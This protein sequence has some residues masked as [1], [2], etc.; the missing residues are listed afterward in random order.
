MCSCRLSG[1]TYSA[2]LL[3]LVSH[4]LSDGP[5]LGS[6]EVS[7]VD[8]VDGRA[9]LLVQRCLLTDPVV[10]VPVQRS[11]VVQEGLRQQEEKTPNGNHLQAFCLPF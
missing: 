3:A 11:V 10:D 6:Q 4:L 7:Q 5:A 2:E 1:S 8:S 9:G